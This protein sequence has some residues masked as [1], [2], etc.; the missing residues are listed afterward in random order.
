[1]HTASFRSTRGYTIVAALL[2]ELAFWRGEESSDPDTEILA[3][4]K[5]GMATIP[6]AMLL[7]ASSPYARRGALWETYRKH[8]GKD[9]DPVLI[10]QAPT[11]T[12]NSTV[13]QSVIDAAMEADPSSASA[14]Y[15]AE[16]RSDIEGFVTREVAEA[17]VPVGVFERMPL[18]ALRYF[19]FVDPSGGSNDAF[20]LG[21][22]HRE[23]ENVLLD[24]V[25]EVRPPFSPE[26]VIGEFAT[27]F[28]SYRI[29]RI[30]GD[31]YAGE[32]PREIFR[33]LG[34]IYEPSQKPKSDLYWDYC[35]C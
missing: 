15:M 6:G 25:R 16:F 8:F 29:T 35:R 5:P 17:C 2:D 22:A 14:E 21:I 4:I 9:G 20:T 13:P 12:M 27:T 33:K 28:K 3:A 7:C 1:M 24:C 23:N 30:I 19:G 26:A 11:R 31:R 18:T 34:I 10:W 32:F